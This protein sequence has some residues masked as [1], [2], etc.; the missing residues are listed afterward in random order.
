MTKSSIPINGKRLAD[1]WSIE[2]ADLIHIIFSHNLNV[3]HPHDG[4]MSLNETL[5]RFYKDKDTPKYVFSLAEVKEIEA[6][7]GVD[8]K[9]PLAEFIRCN[10]LMARWEMHD[11]EIY[12]I[13]S[14]KGLEAIDPFGHEIGNDFL[15]PLI[16]SGTLD[17]SDLLFRLTDI[18]DFESNHPEIVPEQADDE[19]PEKKQRPSQIHREKCR[20]MAKKLWEEDPTLT[21]VDMTYKDEINALF[22]GKVYT[23][24]TIRKWIKV[25]CPDRTPGRRSKKK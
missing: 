7:L 10:D 19:E 25:E 21:I 11:D 6:K 14:D 4:V 15:L 16:E 20:E 23:E 5:E 8:G 3:S 2:T 13:M 24:K 17:V 9:I 22:D 1:R 18:E 12:M